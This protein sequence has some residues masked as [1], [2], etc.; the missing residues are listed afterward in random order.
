MA[1]SSMSELTLIYRKAN[2]QSSHTCEYVEL[3]HRWL[4]LT[5]MSN[6][7]QKLHDSQTDCYNKNQT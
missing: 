2:F 6:M 1:T 4:G 7:G 3:H 5:S